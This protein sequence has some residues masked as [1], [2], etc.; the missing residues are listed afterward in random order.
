MHPNVK[1]YTD[2]ANKLDSAFDYSVEQIKRRQWFFDLNYKFFLSVGRV[3]SELSCFHSKYAEL[4]LC[5]QENMYPYVSKCIQLPL[6]YPKVSKCIQVTC[7]SLKF[8]SRINYYTTS[9][10]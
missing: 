2:E 5:K 1:I 3:V 9:P 6:L 4:T 10:F 8:I 7:F